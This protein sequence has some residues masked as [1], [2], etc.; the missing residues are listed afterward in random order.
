ME[1]VQMA[2]D[3]CVKTNKAYEELEGLMENES[4]LRR[5][6]IK[7][8]KA[9]CEERT[10]TQMEIEQLRQESSIKAFYIQQLEKAKGNGHSCQLEKVENE[11]IR[12]VNS[13]SDTLARVT[14]LRL[15]Q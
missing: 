3:A 6:V 15:S 4:G 1:H 14:Q 2:W 8:M 5:L 7:L 10:A 12:L 9:V 13:T 11:L